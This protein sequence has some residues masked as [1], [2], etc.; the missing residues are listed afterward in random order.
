MKKLFAA[1]LAISLLFTPAAS[2]AGYDASKYHYS[3]YSTAVRA[4]QIDKER[5]VFRFSTTCN[6][7]AGY[8]LFMASNFNGNPWKDIAISDH[9][10]KDDQVV[11]VMT[12]YDALT[13]HL[14]LKENP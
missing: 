7:P 12:A 3:C 14:V 5:I 8:R 11:F 10:V 6:D 4:T 13:H 2:H 1:L 9:A